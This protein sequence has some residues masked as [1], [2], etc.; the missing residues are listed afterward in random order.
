MVSNKFLAG[1]AA[2]VC[3]AQ[4]QA[5]PMPLTTNLSAADHLVAGSGKSYAF[6]I[7]SLLTSNGLSA[8]AIAFGQLTVTGH[9]DAVYGS[10]WDTFGNYV[11]TGTSYHY[12][13]GACNHGNCYVPD[14]TYTKSGTS[15]HFDFTSDTMLVTVGDTTG[16][17][18]SEW[19]E[20][21]TAFTTTL[22]KK[23]GSDRYG[24]NYY[25]TYGNVHYGSY[26]GDLSVTLNLDSKAIAD[27]VKDG[28]LSLSVWG[29]NGQFNIDNMRLNLLAID[30]P[31]PPAD[32]KIPVPT[33]LLLT[34][35]GLAVL[36]TVRRRRSA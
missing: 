17:D 11:L 21:S 27:I 7:N 31:T 20:S 28:I 33:S 13:A 2:L 8:A 3:A 26:S 34:G 9:S 18:T 30:L 29:S 35:L 23:S 19:Q 36:A 32:A 24:W 12:N 10:N 6:D 4:V 14:R 1:I 16:S 22:D 25:N 15:N 5:A